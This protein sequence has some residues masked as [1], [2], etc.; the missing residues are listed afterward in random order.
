LAI[1]GWPSLHYTTTAPLLDRRAE[2]GSWTLFDT[3]SGWDHVHA[4]QAKTA[5][6]VLVPVPP[7]AE[8]LPLFDLFLPQVQA[9]MGASGRV[10]LLITRHANRHKH[11]RAI[12]GEMIS[13]FGSEMVLPIMVRASARFN[14]A[15]EQGLSIFDSAPQSTGAADFAQLARTL[16]SYAAQLRQAKG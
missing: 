15:Q 5:D 1:S 16:L 6:L 2:M 7:M 9:A 11:H 12:L 13:R 14:N 4:E 3:A 10:N 8:S